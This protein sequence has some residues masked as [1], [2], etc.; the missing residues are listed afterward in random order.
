M[1]LTCSSARRC[2]HGHYKN[3]LNREVRT[4][5][6][7]LEIQETFLRRRLSERKELAAIVDEAKALKRRS[8]FLRVQDELRALAFRVNEEIVEAN[9]GIRRERMDVTEARNRLKRAKRFRDSELA[10]LERKYD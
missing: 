8:K 9:D 3:A 5:Q 6:D 7:S 2:N 10:H 4:A 1:K